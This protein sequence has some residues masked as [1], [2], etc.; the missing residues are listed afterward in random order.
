M[1][2]AKAQ[3]VGIRELLPKPTTAQSLAEAVDRVL[4]K[5]KGTKYA[6]NFAH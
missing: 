2:P 3:A 4:K 5:E 6:P 1:T